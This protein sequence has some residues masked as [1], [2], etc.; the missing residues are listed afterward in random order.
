[1]AD[2]PGKLKEILYHVTTRVIQHTNNSCNIP[3]SVD[4]SVVARHCKR[5]CIMVERKRGDS[6]MQIPR[7]LEGLWFIGPRA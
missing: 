3:I 1:M 2:G 5:L 4:L 7:R 6:R